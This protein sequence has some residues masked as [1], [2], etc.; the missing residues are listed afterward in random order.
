MDTSCRAIP[1]VYRWEIAFKIGF[2]EDSF[3]DNAMR[4]ASVGAGAFFKTACSK[5]RMPRNAARRLQTAFAGKRRF[6]RRF[7]ARYPYASYGIR[8]PPLF[9]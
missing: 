6:A 1:F 4:A 2:S 9:L 8:I 3:Q 5:G 7:A